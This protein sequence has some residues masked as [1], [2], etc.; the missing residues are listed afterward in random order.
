MKL[1]IFTPL[2]G[3]YSETFIENHIKYLCDD[4]VIITTKI[5]NNKFPNIPILVIDRINVFDKY[6]YKIEK[7]I[8]D[9]LK[10]YG[11]THI[12]VEFPPI[13]AGIFE[14]NIRVFKL[15]IIAH[16]HGWD[17]SSAL[18]HEKTIKFYNWMGKYV[19]KIITVSEKMKQKL[20]QYAKINENK[21]IVNYYGIKPEK[22]KNNIKKNNQVCRLIFVGRFVE[23]KGP[24][25]LLEAFKL[26]YEKN[27]NIELV[28]IGNTPHD[29]NYGNLFEKAKEF[30]KKEN[31]EN[32][33]TL[34]GV[35]SHD[36]IFEELGKSDIYVQHSR[37]CP[38]SGDSEGLPNSILEA[39]SME[40]PII[41]TFHEGIPEAVKNG[42]NGFL[43][44]ENDVKHMAECILKLS[45][46]LK[47]REYL[48][49]NSKKIFMEKF[50]LTKSINRLKRII[51]KQKWALSS[52]MAEKAINEYNKIKLNKWLINKIKELKLN[53]YFICMYGIGYGFQLN[54][55]TL[56][57]LIDNKYIDF[58]V[59]DNKRN[60][61]CNMKIHS[62]DSLIK[63]LYLENKQYKIAFIITPIN[64]GVF[65]K[66]VKKVK[67]KLKNPLIIKLNKNLL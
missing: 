37:K 8:T 33:V 59:D 19:N 2:I 34:K 62:L 47:L 17:A 61:I 13:F 15:P 45:N 6:S 14:L 43:V 32:V 18:K 9:F 53:N 65:F 12:L 20:I 24:L 63:Y 41:S 54:Y 56:K 10:K 36:E 27:K 21:I 67:L 64:K 57:Y 50:H 31:L 7:K 40:L 11:I 5:I 28:M 52:L 39:M 30:I 38:Y 35:L 23:K 44:K 29:Y 22:I 42:V 3:A 48:G 25:L 46:N 60:K 49:K 51:E 58:I 55:P 4:L 66:I 1:A 26:A 16:F